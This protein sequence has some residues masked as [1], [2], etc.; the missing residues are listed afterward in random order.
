MVDHGWH[1]SL[2]ADILE[3]DSRMLYRPMRRILRAPSSHQG[4]LCGHQLQCYEHDARIPGE[5][6]IKK[7]KQSVNGRF[8]ATRAQAKSFHQ[9]R[10]IETMAE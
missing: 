4:M 7:S 3:D 8:G 10:R 1:S 5:K 2:V 6:K 9:D